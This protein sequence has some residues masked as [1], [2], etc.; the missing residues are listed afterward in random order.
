[1]PIDAKNI[2]R[3]GFL[4]LSGGVAAAAAA[5]SVLGPID[6]AKAEAPAPGFE[7]RF[8]VC[9]MCFNK[10]G[11]IARIQNGVV[12]KLDP[13][14]KFHKSRGMLCARGNAGLKQHYD[15]DRLKYPL[16]RQGER[17]EGRWKQISW[18]Q[19]LDLMAEK[20]KK[21]AEKY[22]RCGVMF[23]AGTDMQALFVSRFAEAFGSYNVMSHESQCLV[24]GNRAFLDTFGEVPIP[25]VLN[26]KYV[27]M[28]GANRFEALVTPDSMDLVTAMK[29]GCKLVVFDPRY[30][31]TAAR[32]H[33][34]HP[35]RPGTDMALMLAIAHVLTAEKRYDQ[36]FVAEKC[37]GL[38]QLTEHVKP[39]SP[40]WAEKETEVPAE[41]IRRIAR[42][43]AANAPQAMIYPGRRSSDYKD[44][45]QIRRAFAIVNA[46]LGNW[47]RPGGLTAA[48]ATG[49]KNPGIETPFYDDNPEKRV[50]AGPARL[51]LEETGSFKI[52]R[53]AVISEKPYPVKGFFT[54]HVNPV[55]TVANRA[56]T[57]EMYKKLDFAVSMDIVMSDTAWLADLVLPAQSALERQDPC[58][59]VQGASAGACVV[60]RDP[61]VDQPY[62]ESRPVFR[63][64]K[65]LADRLDLAEFFDIT[66]EDYRKK[67]LAG[68]PGAMEALL[69]DG[70]YYHPSEMY[71]LY[72]G[73]I[74]KT[75]SHKIEL[76]NQ[77][78][79]EMGLDPMPVYRA[80]ARVPEGGYRLVVGRNALLTQTG[81]QNNSL[82]VEF[83]PDNDLWIHPEAA[84]RLKISHGDMV[85]VSRGEVR[86]RI[87][88]NVTR[89]T[90]P[91][92]VYM[93]SGFGVISKGLTRIYG[94]GAS[95]AELLND[96]MDELTGN[97]AMHE[98]MVTVAKEGA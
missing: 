37:F 59:A 39:Y 81:S 28:C 84:A 31:H 44:S 90:R 73:K 29:Q 93:H 69:K 88:A 15:P 63:V 43:L 6:P 20:F 16:L 22:T 61:V 92:T 5:G 82:L 38:E 40:E 98:T 33:E 45:T 53:D 2:S 86:Q 12:V 36:K 32:A 94:K 1:M 21:I 41:A 56:K 50:D 77:T 66:I 74:F 10:C 64:M 51:M 97:M 46:L 60:M 7:S 75:K 57:I 13:N 58:S 70:V 47:D 85:V 3:R 24:S 14:P 9:D 80:P 17:G 11:F 54:Y 4:K 42:E 72:E 87:R 48:R 68:L 35:I 34:W 30:T 18:D 76:F 95:I 8:G 79:K 27:A 96:D 78:Y 19:A 49:L 89:L 83:V 25:D 55:G 65:D 23:M 26:C 67:Q 91:D 62:F 52:A 71:G